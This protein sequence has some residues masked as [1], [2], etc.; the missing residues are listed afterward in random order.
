MSTYEDCSDLFNNVDFKD[1]SINCIFYDYIFIF[2]FIISIRSHS[3]ALNVC[4]A[5]DKVRGMIIFPVE[6]NVIRYCIKFLKMYDHFGV[7]RNFVFYSE[8]SIKYKSISGF[9]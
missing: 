2:Y 9:Y 4:I 3:I 6:L 1:N 7:K 5:G 8:S